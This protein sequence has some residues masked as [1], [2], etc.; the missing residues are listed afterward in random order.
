MRYV[1][2][3][4]MN[5]TH[6]I[7]CH[8]TPNYAWHLCDGRCI[9]TSC[10]IKVFHGL[11]HLSPSPS[12]PTI[13]HFCCIHIEEF[14][15]IPLQILVC[16]LVALYRL[17]DGYCWFRGIFCLHWFALTSWRR[18]QLVGL[19]CSRAKTHGVSAQKTTAWTITAM[20][21]S[22]LIHV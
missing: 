14:N 20:K 12:Y 4:Y 6:F 8:V 2:F 13:H 5:I 9:R 17:V 10:A 19:K 3:Q 11:A 15:Y 16:W 7:L 22:K 18:R 21:I 1:H